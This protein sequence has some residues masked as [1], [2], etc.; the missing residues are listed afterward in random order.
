MAVEGGL[1]AGEAVQRT[2][3]PAAKLALVA[4]RAA[5]RADGADLAFVTAT[6]ADRDGLMVPRSK[7]RV[8]FEVSGPAE[9]VATDNG[10]AT[11]HDSFQ[12]RE[13]AAFNGLALVIIRTKAGEPG[14]I[15]LRA[16]ADGLAAAET[17]LN[18]Q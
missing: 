3:G 9:I 2:T 17:I 7:Q 4:D 18:S 5:L 15:T 10:D 6:I 13:R 14:P 16:K 12:A 8:S 1:R 11:D